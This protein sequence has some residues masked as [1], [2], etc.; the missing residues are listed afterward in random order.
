MF[1]V[2]SIPDLSG[3]HYFF[4]AISC[5]NFY[6]QKFPSWGH[7]GWRSGR[8]GWW[9]AGRLFVLVDSRHQQQEKH[10]GAEADSRKYRLLFPETFSQQG[11]RIV[12]LPIHLIY[13]I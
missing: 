13:G 10:Q 4:R 3:L 2:S 5:G 1:W 12:P 6:C 8:Q 7:P 9:G 11:N